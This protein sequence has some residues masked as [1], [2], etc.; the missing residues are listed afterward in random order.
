M[1]ATS[2]RTIKVLANTTE[3]ALATVPE[4]KTITLDTNGK[5]INYTATTE[6]HTAPDNSWTANC[7]ILNN[8][9]LNITGSGTITAT[10]T[11]PDNYD[12]LIITMGPLNIIGGTIQTGASATA[13]Y[14]EVFTENEEIY[15]VDSNI[16]IGTNDSSVSTTSPVI[17]GYVGE[18][19]YYNTTYIS[20][21]SVNFYDGVYYANA[22][23]NDSVFATGNY[24]YF[25]IKSL[26]K[27]YNY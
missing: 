12:C 24:A 4:D 14:S 16:T 17:I 15:D 9:T 18:A 25:A 1:G 6:A 7:C 3:T 21:N 13:I 20:L 5:T 19:T 23:S 10:L 11:E 2:G 27:Y 22:N 8:G 26:F